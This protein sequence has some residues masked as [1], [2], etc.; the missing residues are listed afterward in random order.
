[1]TKGCYTVVLADEFSVDRRGSRA[2]RV[3]PD[4][5][6]SNA[7]AQPG[8]E[9]TNSL[10]SLIEITPP[11]TDQNAAKFEL[12]PNP[13]TVTAILSDGSTLTAEI[14]Y[15][16]QFGVGYARIPVPGTLTVTEARSS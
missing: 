6:D 2:G 3:R 8:G 16:E 13:T 1:M 11:P 15:G 10:V 14:N 5:D 7:G 9:R 12:G 4:A